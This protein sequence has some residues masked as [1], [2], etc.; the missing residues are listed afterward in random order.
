M[1]QVVR[2]R[3]KG[4]RKL[5]L[6]WDK[7]KKKQKREREKQ[8][9]GVRTIRRK[10]SKR[11]GKRDKWHVK[12]RNEDCGRKFPTLI[13]LMREVKRRR[14]TGEKGEKKRESYA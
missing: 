9:V 7:K 5:P 1:C 11:K 8:F 14:K 4:E 2:R 3:K 6:T 10:E 13:K 12:K